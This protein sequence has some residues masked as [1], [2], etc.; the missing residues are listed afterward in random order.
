MKEELNRCGKEFVNTW[1]NE[2][3]GTNKRILNK[4]Y[5]L[6]EKQALFSFIKT[7]YQTNKLKTRIISPDSFINKAA[8]STACR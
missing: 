2:V 7:R 6:E 5:L 3:R 1:H 4:H 8:A